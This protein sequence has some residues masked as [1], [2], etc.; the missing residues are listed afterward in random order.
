MDV[1]IDLEP[2]KIPEVLEDA[3]PDHPKRSYL[4]GKEM[5]HFHSQQGFHPI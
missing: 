5:Q 4:H 2:A 1:V 3:S